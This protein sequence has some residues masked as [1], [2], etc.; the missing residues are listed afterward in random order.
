M[1]RILLCFLLSSGWLAIG[2]PSRAAVVSTVDG[3]SV[4]FREADAAITAVR[5]G[6]KPL[7]L[8]GT[9]GGFYVVDMIGD[10]MLGKMDYKSAGFAGTRLEGT[11]R[12]SPTGL[13]IEGKVND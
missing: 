13:V 9:P 3:L 10:K 7:K 2:A 1:Y 6:G 11:A 4:E 8:N 12:S 5:I